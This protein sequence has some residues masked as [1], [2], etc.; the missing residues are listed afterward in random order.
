[1][2]K[3]HPNTSAADDDG[4]GGGGDDDDDWDQWSIPTAN[5]S[6]IKRNDHKPITPLC[7]GLLTTVFFSFPSL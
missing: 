6:K 7:V 2:K 3:H 1:M 4:D 5:I